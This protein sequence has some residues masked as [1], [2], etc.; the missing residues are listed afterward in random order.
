MKN[1]LLMVVGKLSAGKLSVKRRKNVLF[2]HLFSLIVAI[3]K[4]LDYYM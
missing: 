4:Q 1:L 2:L 3:C